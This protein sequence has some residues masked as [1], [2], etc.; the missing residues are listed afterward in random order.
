HWQD[1]RVDIHWPFGTHMFLKTRNVAAL[2]LTKPSKRELAKSVQVDRQTFDISSEPL[3]LEKV[4]DRWTV[5]KSYPS[6]SGPRKLPGLQ[7]RNDDVFFSPFLVVTPSGKSADPQ[8]D[9]WVEFEVEHFRD[10]WRRLFRGDVRMKPDIE[11]SGD[12]LRKYHLILWGDAQS[13]KIL[14]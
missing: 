12:D 11:V 9:R 2:K 6:D 5:V 4:S 7:G 14:A 3:I 1:S 8:L 13:N 10:R